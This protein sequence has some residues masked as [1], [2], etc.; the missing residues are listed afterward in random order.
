MTA[1]AFIEL[2]KTKQ[3]NIELKKIL[4]Y[5][6]DNEDGQNTRDI[7]LGVKMGNVFALAKEFMFMD[8]EEVEKLLQSPIHEA[9]V[10]AV[11]IMDFKARDKRASRKGTS[12]QTLH[13]ML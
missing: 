3:S 2:L 5:L 1:K 13:Q 4:K 10:G 12:I 8:L 6:K 7:F 9:R 11:S